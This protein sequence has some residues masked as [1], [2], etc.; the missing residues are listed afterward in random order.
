M[1]GVADLTTCDKEN[2]AGVGLHDAVSELSLAADSPD[3]FLS[4][5][6]SIFVAVV[7]HLI[8]QYLLEALIEVD[9]QQL[10][11]YYL[12]YT[13]LVNSAFRTR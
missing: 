3:V 8:T 2:S 11:Y 6:L 12:V 9:Q 4:L 10:P 1:D 5:L 13:T 7:V